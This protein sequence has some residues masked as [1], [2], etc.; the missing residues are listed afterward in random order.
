MRGDRYGSSRLARLIACITA[1]HA[2]T[3][4]AATATPKF[5]RM[6]RR[7]AK[8]AAT[9]GVGASPRGALAAAMR[10]LLRVCQHVRGGNGRLGAHRSW[11]APLGAGHDRNLSRH[12][13]VTDAAVLV[14]DD[15]VLAWC[16]LRGELA[17]VPRH[18]HRL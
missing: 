8:V 2:A 10:C 1:M 6:M 11:T 18:N 12:Y 9:C 17:H 16:E 15:Q 13:V 3:P 5:A 7:S 4:N 14:A